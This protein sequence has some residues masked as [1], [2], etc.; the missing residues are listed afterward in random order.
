MNMNAKESA[1]IRK[2]RRKLKNQLSEENKKINK[3]A[4][5]QMS[6]NIKRWIS[7]HAGER[8]NLLSKTFTLFDENQHSVFPQDQFISQL[9][10]ALVKEPSPEE[11]PEA[12]IDLTEAVAKPLEGRISF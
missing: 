1:H 3:K 2:A 10:Q 8:I 6:I 11:V 4:L 5:E 7:R 12:T 9:A